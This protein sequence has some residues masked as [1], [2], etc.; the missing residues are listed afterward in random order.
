MK[1]DLPKQRDVEDFDVRQRMT[2]ASGD[3]KPWR[4]H[5]AVFSQLEN[6]IVVTSMRKNNKLEQLFINKLASSE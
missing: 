2:K 3:S 1:S 4:Q 5:R 6:V